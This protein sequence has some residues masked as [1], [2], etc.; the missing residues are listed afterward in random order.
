MR[1]LLVV[2]D[3]QNDF[4][5]GSIGSDQARSIVGNVVKKINHFDG[6]VIATMDTH[7]D[8]D[9][10]LKSQEG[11]NLPVLHCQTGTDGWNMVPEVK[12]AFDKKKDDTYMSSIFIKPTFGSITM[13]KTVHYYSNKLEEIEIV[14]VCTDICV[15]SNALLLK[16][17][18]PEV[19]ITVDASCCAG[20]TP[21]SHR[22]ALATMKACQIN[23]INDA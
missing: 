19:K 22:A 23:V 8:P 10:Y 4:V 14:G 2:V 7:T 3:M 12:E 16:A 21:E 13:A 11:R 15:V 1:K 20:V 9:R 17:Y 18:L 6:A 5:F